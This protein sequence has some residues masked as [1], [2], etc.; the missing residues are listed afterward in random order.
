MRKC[1][2]DRT[3]QIDCKSNEVI[4]DQILVKQRLLSTFTGSFS[5]KNVSGEKVE[6]VG[7]NFT[8]PLLLLLLSGLEVSITSFS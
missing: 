8:S 2:R 1:P 7:E 5:G 3:P 4:P 6:K